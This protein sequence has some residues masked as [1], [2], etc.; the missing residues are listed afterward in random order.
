MTR[1]PYKWGSDQKLAVIK[2]HSLAKHEVLR[3]YLL[4]YFQTLVT[5]QQEEPRL[6]LVD[7]F[8]GGGVYHHEVTGGVVLG[9]P[10]VFLEA[11]K[12]AE[13]L[14]N[15]DRQKALRLNADYFFVDIDQAALALLE[16]TLR[17]EGHGDRIGRDIRLLKGRFEAVAESIRS[18]IR[19][20]N[21][22]NGRSLFFLDQ[23]GYKEVPTPLIR[24]IFAEL[25]AAEVILTFNVDAFISYASDTPL[26]AGLLQQIGIPDVLQGR[27]I[28]DIKRSERDFRLYIQSCLY[29]GL[30]EACGA[31]FYTVFFIRTEGHGD[32]WLVHLSQHPRAQDVMTRVHWAQNNN[33]IHYGGAG[34]DMFRVLGYSADRDVSLTGQSSFGFCFDDPAAQASVSALME[35]LPR[36]IHARPEGMSFGELFAATCNTTPADSSKFKEALAKLVAHKE[37]E[38]VSI[39]SG[40]SKAEENG[41]LG[42]HGFAPD[43]AGMVSGSSRGR[44]IFPRV[45]EDGEAVA[46]KEGR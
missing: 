10:F 42:N 2:R 18:S 35:Q 41:R 44:D 45:A 32:Y 11:A 28:E 24:T 7:G 19:S 46:V 14:I 43:D 25:P 37:I 8:A 38:I 5:P 21:P 31:R 20:K 40:G 30:V 29:R 23:Y 34:I 9:S 26:T 16:Q 27:S 4:E 1:A 15:R 6:T 36:V 22:R 39:V 3:T 13:E 12:E 17:S 33:F